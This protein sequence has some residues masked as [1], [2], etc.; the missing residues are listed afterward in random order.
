VPVTVCPSPEFLEDPGG[1]PGW[2]VGQAI[3]NSLRP[4]G[5]LF[6]VTRIPV[7]VVLNARKSPGL[8][9]CWLAVRFYR[10]ESLTRRVDTLRKLCCFKELYD[11][12]DGL[13]GAV[14]GGFEPA[15]GA[16]ARVRAVVETAVGKRATEPLM[17]EE[18]E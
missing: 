1:L 11:V 18:E 13:V 16:V 14:I 3:A 2:R 9:R 6:R 7:R 17:K 12:V 4:G 8:F 15:I 5:L 10:V